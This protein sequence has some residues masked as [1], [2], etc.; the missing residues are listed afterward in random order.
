MEEKNRIMS[1][2]EDQDN[3]DEEKTNEA[4]CEEEE[5]EQEGTPIRPSDVDIVRLNGA[6]VDE[7]IE[8]GSLSN[9][10]PKSNSTREGSLPG[11]TILPG[12]EDGDASGLNIDE[13][14]DTL[15]GDREGDTKDQSNNGVVE[16]VEKP[17]LSTD[18]LSETSA[19]RPDPPSILDES[20]LSM[21]N[22]DDNE[23]NHAIPT[24]VEPS[25]DDLET[26]KSSLGSPLQGPM[27][28]PSK[29]EADIA[30]FLV[31]MGNTP[32]DKTKSELQEEKKSSLDN[33]E[34]VDQDEGTFN[35]AGEKSRPTHSPGPSPV[36]NTNTSYAIGK[37]Q[38]QLPQEQQ[39]ANPP[40]IMQPALEYM[41]IRGASPD[42]DIQIL[43]PVDENRLHVDPLQPQGFLSHPPPL[44]QQIHPGYLHHPMQQQQQQPHPLSHHHA[45][46]PPPQ[47]TM[48]LQQTSSST[49]RKIR[50]RLQEERSHPIHHPRQS[51]LG[52]LRKRSQ[53]MMFG[54][55]SFSHVEDDTNN[56]MIFDNIDRGNI[57]VSWFVGTS[58]L[59]LH[60]HV[61]RSVIRKLKLEK[62]VQLVDMRLLDE[63][64]DPPEGMY[65]CMCMLA[66]EDF[67]ICY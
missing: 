19:S 49:R 66:E 26:E 44:Q 56:D 42:R 16:Q 14:G 2:L 64:V 35:V 62:H 20:L 55:N 28:A 7:N 36:I 48:M 3:P 60:E 1:P 10:P 33:E 12:E 58:S 45:M 15:E 57:S 23:D 22:L 38:P 43:P 63:T 41:N 37:Q 21:E 25:Y 31:D 39:Q 65:V 53:N 52:H 34:S 51:I 67:F 46:Q 30:T 9:L 50:L 40:Q 4:S 24:T 17:L 61:R 54:S 18:L 59:E 5:Q 29:A 47:P 27:Q 32:T 13:K 8:E 6:D 11:K